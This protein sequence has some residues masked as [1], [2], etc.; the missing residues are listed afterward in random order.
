MT[1]GDSGCW[2]P[3]EWSGLGTPPVFGFQVDGGGR[4]Q[5][6]MLVWLLVDRACGLVSILGS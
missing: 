6:G 1:L 4:L 3:G 2:K 5:A